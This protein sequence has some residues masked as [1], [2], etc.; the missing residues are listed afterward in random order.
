M[1][2]VRDIFQLKF[3]QSK[4]ATTLWKQGVAMM[5]SKTNGR[6][7]LLT[8]VAG[9]AYYTLILE[10]TWDSIAQWEQATEG[11]RTDPD[12]QKWYPK[13]VALTESGRREIL[14]I[15]E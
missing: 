4:E 1:I 6:A 12:W 10:S 15:I 2:V 13:V 7:R 11:V 5:A 3:G 9:A 8:D 14:S